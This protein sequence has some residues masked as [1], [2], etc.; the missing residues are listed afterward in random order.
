M[1][2]TLIAL[3]AAIK[4]KKLSFDKILNTPTCKLF[5]LFIVIVHIS[6]R[7]GVNPE[8]VFDSDRHILS[9]KTR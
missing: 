4:D 7:F 8:P 9:Q 1:I 6:T 2:I 3:F 5:L